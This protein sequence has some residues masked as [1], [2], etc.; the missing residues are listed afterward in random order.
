MEIRKAKKIKP[1]HI[2]FSD[3]YAERLC[4][5]DAFIISHKHILKV[6]ASN[7]LKNDEV[8]ELVIKKARDVHK[9]YQKTIVLYY[10]QIKAITGKSPF[11]LLKSN[12]KGHRNPDCIE[13]LK[14]LGFCFLFFNILKREYYLEIIRASVISE[15]EYLTWCMNKN[16]NWTKDYNKMKTEMLKYNV[17]F[18]QILNKE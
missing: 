6:E 13:V 2:I 18:D 9:P 8:W 17:H 14:N 12:K 5:L 1:H 4:S 11:K 7:L 15:M 10:D 3:Y 16:E